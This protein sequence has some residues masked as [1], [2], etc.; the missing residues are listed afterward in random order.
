[1]LLIHLFA[2][3]FVYPKEILWSDTIEAQLLQAMLLQSYKGKWYPKAN[4]MS[5]YDDFTLKGGKLFKDGSNVPFTGWYAQ[6][7]DLGEP[8][9]LCTFDNGK[10]NGFTYLW[11]SN[12]TRR[13]Q[14]EY[15]NNAKNGQFLEWN[16]NGIQISEKN[17]KNN[18]LSGEYQLWY[19]SGKIKMDAI[20][21]GGKLRNA[22]GWYP[23]GKPCP[24]SKVANGRGIILRYELNFQSDNT[25]NFN[26][27]E[28]NDNLKPLPDLQFP[29]LGQSDVW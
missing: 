1:M 6:F 12:G 25:G 21:E 19:D 15:L 3:N 11:D 29:K 18:Q 13:F 10:K 4:K 8:R 2:L 23:D 16:T 22:R 7:D 27:P 24:Y 5:P 28:G 20:F 17:Y 14:G 26:F 9:M